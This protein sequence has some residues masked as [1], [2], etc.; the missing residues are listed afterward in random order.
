VQHVLSIAQ[1][2]EVYEDLRDL[3]QE[4]E[5][6]A[7]M[8]RWRVDGRATCESTLGA[9]IPS[10]GFDRYPT[11]EEKAARI[12]VGIVC[13]H[14][15]VDGNKRLGVFTAHRQFLVNGYT[16]DIT[17]DELI[18]MTYHVVE[19]RTDGMSVPAISAVIAGRFNMSVVPL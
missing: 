1:L 15:L 4:G 13:G 5:L 19:A 18:D 14:P 11:I 6:D 8:G 3:H 2:V 9:L 17:D 7:P 10:F 16:L 12:M